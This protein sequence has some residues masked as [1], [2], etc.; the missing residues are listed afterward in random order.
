[1]SLPVYRT[2][3]LGHIISLRGLSVNVEF[4]SGL[5]WAAEPH[6]FDQPL[7]VVAL[8]EGL[9]GRSDLFDVAKYPPI[10][11]LLFERAVVSLNASGQNI[12]TGTFL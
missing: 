4:T 6:F 11:C 8:D 3:F 5:I 7:F 9:H 10:D 2:R 12:K 1:M